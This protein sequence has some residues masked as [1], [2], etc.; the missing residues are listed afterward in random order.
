MGAAIAGLG[1]RLLGRHRRAA[2]GGQRSLRGRNPRWPRGQRTL[3][4]PTP[5]VTYTAAQQTVDWGAPLPRGATLRIRLFQRS[6]R[7]GRGAPKT[8]TLTL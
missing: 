4:T 5:A 3:A 6:L 1:R 7:V 8:V 2:R